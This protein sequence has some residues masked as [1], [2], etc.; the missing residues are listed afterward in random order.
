MFKMLKASVSE[1]LQNMSS[2]R[3]TSNNIRN[4]ERLNLPKPRTNYLKRNFCCSGAL[5][6]NNLPQ[7]IRKQQSFPQFRKAIAEHYLLYKYKDLFID[8]DV[9]NNRSELA[10]ANRHQER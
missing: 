8:M 2:V 3:G 10:I 5:L 9:R 1:Y 7:D 6:W 4:S